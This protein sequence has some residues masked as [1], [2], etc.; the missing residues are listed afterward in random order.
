MKELIVFDLDGTLALTHHRDHFVRG[1]RKNWRAFFAACVDDTP[2]EPAIAVFK[3]L[4]A[5]GY[6]MEIW[7]GRSDEVRAETEEW[8]AA[9][10][11]RPERL[12]MRKQDD[13]TPDH[14]LKESW[15]QEAHRK[16]MVIFD[17]RNKVVNMWRSH[18]VACF[19]VAEGNF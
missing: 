14:L 2:N 5:Q 18:G 13:Y 15:L 19:Q 6:S 3:A 12:R 1:R 8:L 16:P 7:S 10:G 4:Q 11:I 17:D 9:Q